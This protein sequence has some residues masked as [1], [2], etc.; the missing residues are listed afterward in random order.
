MSYGV[1]LDPRQI[2][3]GL[4]VRDLVDHRLSMRRFEGRRRVV[5]IDPADAM[6]V[7]AQKKKGSNGNSRD[8]NRRANGV[9]FFRTFQ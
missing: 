3:P 7:Q 5:V 1:K 6:N 4:S 9:P 8:S 2:T